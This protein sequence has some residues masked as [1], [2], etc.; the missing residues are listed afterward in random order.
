MQ[1]YVKQ[2]VRTESPT[3]NPP[4]PRLMH[5]SLGLCT[6]SAELLGYD[7]SVNLLEELGDILWYVALACHEMQQPFPEP[8]GTDVA[9]SVEVIIFQTGAF[10]D[11]IKRFTFYYAPVAIEDLMVPLAVIVSHVDILAREAGSSLAEVQSANIAKLRAR[12]PDKFDEVLCANRDLEEEQ[13]A[14]V[15]R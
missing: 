7:S 4:S 6:E 8:T 2:A 5:V 14:L 3:Y 9:D 13:R 15:A 11:M 10:V 1:N 12:F